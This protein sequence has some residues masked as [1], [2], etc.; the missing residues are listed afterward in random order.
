MGCISEKQSSKKVEKKASDTIGAKE[1]SGQSKKLEVK[2]DK[3]KEVKDDKKVNRVTEKVAKGLSVDVQLELKVLKRR[4]ETQ[5]A[6]D[7]KIE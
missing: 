6:V 2:D 1:R 7:A 4:R 5:K 3:K